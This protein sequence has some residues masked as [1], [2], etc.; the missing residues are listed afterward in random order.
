MRDRSRDQESRNQH[1]GALLLEV[2]LGFGIFATALLLAFGVFP[3]SQRAAGQSRNYTLANALAKENLQEELGKDPASVVSRPPSNIQR[4]I[5]SNSADPI[6]VQFEEEIVVTPLA[7][8]P[9]APVNVSN[10]ESI[11]RW[12]ERSAIGRVQRT[13]KYEAWITQ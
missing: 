4:F 1:R 9:M 6:T 7:P 11:V 12:D 8:S 5:Y 13:V 2:L 10:V 3:N